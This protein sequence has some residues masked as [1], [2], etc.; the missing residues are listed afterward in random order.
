MRINTATPAVASF[1]QPYSALQNTTNA[2]ETITTSVEDL[3]KDAFVS[4]YRE[5]ALSYLEHIDVNYDHGYFLIKAAQRGDTDIL[6]RLLDRGA[7]AGLTKALL[8]AACDGNKAC[9]ELLI[10]AGADPSVLKDTDAYT[11]Y[12]GMQALVEALKECSAT[13]KPAEKDTQG[14]LSDGHLLEH[15]LPAS[16]GERYVKRQADFAQIDHLLA[17]RPY[18][19]ISGE[20]GVGKTTLAVEYGHHKRQET[21]GAT[22]VVITAANSARHIEETYQQMAAKLGVIVEEM[23]Y[24]EVIQAVHREIHNQQKNLLL[25]LDGVESYQDIIYL[26]YLPDPIKAVV[27]TRYRLKEGKLVINLAPFTPVEAEQFIAL[28]VLG[29]YLQ[30]Q[31]AQALAQYYSKDTA[32]ILP[33]Y[34]DK[35]IKSLTNLRALSQAY[36]NEEGL[37]LQQALMAKSTFAWPLLQ[38]A[39]YL[40]ADFIDL[41]LFKRLLKI[42]QEQLD[43]TVNALTSALM[44]T[45]V[46]KAGQTGLSLPQVMQRIMREVIEYPAY[47]SCGLAKLTIIAELAQI[48]NKL[49]P[50]VEEDPT[51]W[52]Q[53]KG[54]M[55]HIEAVLSQLSDALIS[56]LVA[57][58]WAKK[59]HYADHVLA[60]YNKA[61]IA[62]QKAL[63]IWQKLYPDQPH[64]KVGASLNNV[65][66]SYK[67]LGGLENTIKGLQ[68]SEQA[69]VMRQALYPDQ[70]HLNV[71]NSLNNVGAGYVQLGRQENKIK[72]LQLLEQALV[73]RQALYLDQPHPDVADSLN[74]I[75][76][77]Y[78]QLDGQ[79]H[80]KK[81]FQLQEQALMM[82]QALY[83]DQPHPTV[84]TCLNNVGKNYQELGGLENT[85]KGLQLSEQALVMRQALYPDQPHPDVASSLNNVGV[86]YEQLG[87]QEN[88]IKGLQLQ[89]QALV[90]RQALYPDQ[91]HPN[92]AVSL[93]NMGVGYVQLGGQENAIKGLQL[94]EQA[95]VMRQAVYLDQPHPDV[96]N[97]LNNVGCTYRQLDGQ[98]NRK[99]ALQLQEQALAMY[100]ALYPDQPHPNVAQSLKNIGNLLM[101]LGQVEKGQRYLQ[102]AAEMQDKLNNH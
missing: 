58:L 48:L 102:Q 90:M 54:W 61:L 43:E 98:E 27:T 30:R 2:S 77:T 60:Q 47:P 76:C 65:G 39:A 69:L 74:N 53:A 93:N 88:A 40:D 70:P 44:L 1:M 35:A 18:V 52:R 82:F 21:D 26:N 59:G 9:V 41:N 97:S 55:P 4:G 14:P 6:K 73:M 85:I 56:P 23:E 29:G 92:V 87:G 46:A 42:D 62:H 81:A 36:A 25:I 51:Q 57:S 66:A 64:P 17:T 96:A 101:L 19:I 89:E 11:A 68:L 37:R 49:C 5:K 71:A 15:D 22:L 84:A 7:N 8:A 67:Q 75:G 91:P 79:E 13:V 83:P 78:R 33:G 3:F 45:K 99:K 20:E 50:T 38:Y 86:G 100:Q 32:S 10:G 16:L 80:R 31:E 72:G 24:E 28:S 34:V 95:L 12:P 94:L 63:A